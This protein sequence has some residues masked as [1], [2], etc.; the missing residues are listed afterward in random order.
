MQTVKLLD[1]YVKKGY[2][3]H[4]SRKR[5]DVLIPHRKEKLH[6]STGTLRA[7]YATSIP[8]IA[9]FKA[10]LNAPIMPGGRGMIGWKFDH[11]LN[12]YF[13]VTPNYIRHNAFSSGFVYVLRKEKFKKYNKILC[14][15]YSENPVVP[16]FVI[17]VKKNDF[18]LNANISIW[19]L[20]EV[21]KAGLHNK[22]GIALF[23]F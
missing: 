3:L 8:L 23:G 4:G 13:R 11:E 21:I 5:F 16:D 7:V 14:E 10:V 12:P 19:S 18:L 17:N 6:S 9:L 1:D 20:N 2:V 15:Y 22:E